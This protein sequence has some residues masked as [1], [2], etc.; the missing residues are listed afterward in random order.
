ML[1]DVGASLEAYKSPDTAVWTRRCRPVVCVGSGAA[2]AAHKTSHSSRGLSARTAHRI[3]TLRAG[4][5]ST[6]PVRVPGPLG[7]VHFSQGDYMMRFPVDSLR[8][9]RWSR[10]VPTSCCRRS[11]LGRTLWVSASL[12]QHWRPE[13]PFPRPKSAHWP[14]PPQAPLPRHPPRHLGI[15]GR[16]E[17]RRG[18]A[19]ADIPAPLGRANWQCTFQILHHRHETAGRLDRRRLSW[20]H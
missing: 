19:W 1:P 15:S 8:L 6:R 20:L 10:P 2:A 18:R 3:S 13:R 9:T 17:K 14:Q 16:S 11:K 7:R 4:R 5:A 12:P